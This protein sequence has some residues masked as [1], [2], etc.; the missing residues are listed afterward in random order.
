MYQIAEIFYNHVAGDKMTNEVKFHYL[1]EANNP[2]PVITIGSVKHE[3][4]LNYAFTVQN[5]GDAYSKEEA[6][7]RVLG[8]LN[9]I[10]GKT[11]YTGSV[12]LTK[13]GTKTAILNDMLTRTWDV[14]VNGNT[15]TRC[16]R[17]KAARLVQSWLF[18]YKLNDFVTSTLSGLVDAR[19]YL[20]NRFEGGGR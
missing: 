6:H 7:K 14:N 5:P 10:I 20:L 3:D 2:N 8:R 15:T 16:I 1:K 12:P 11:K 18:G 9:G 17:E 4:R 13:G 19:S